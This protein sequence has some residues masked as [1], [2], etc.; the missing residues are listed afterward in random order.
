MVLSKLHNG[1]FFQI[2]REGAN[3]F[4][5]QDNLGIKKRFGPLKY[6]LKL[7]IVL[8]ARTKNN[9][10]HFKFSSTFKVTQKFYFSKKL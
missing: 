6:L 8:F 5:A 4:F 1:A 10:P 2:F 7:S 9:I 3:S